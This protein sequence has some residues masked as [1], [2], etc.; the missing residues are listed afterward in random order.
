MLN[1]RF[2]DNK[3][4]LHEL[5]LDMRSANMYKYEVTLCRGYG[6]LKAR[7][8]IPIVNAGLLYFTY[9]EYSATCRAF[10]W[11]FHTFHF[12]FLVREVHV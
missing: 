8:K 6:E 12:E 2:A 10:S 9:T 5:G 3:Q 1:L 7:A 11:L 4:V